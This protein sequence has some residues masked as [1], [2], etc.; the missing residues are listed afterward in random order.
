[1]NE[2]P[3]A[4]L[5]TDWRGCFLRGTSTSDTRVTCCDRGACRGSVRYAG[6][7]RTADGGGGAVDTSEIV[8][9]YGAAWD[10]PDQA[11]PRG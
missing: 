9:T 4:Y 5:R 6:D 7:S 10:E 8:A 3:D 2:R 11:K 1:M